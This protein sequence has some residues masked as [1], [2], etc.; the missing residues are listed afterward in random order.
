M[1]DAF[2]NMTA[3]LQDVVHESCSELNLNY[4]VEGLYGTRSDVAEILDR[5]VAYL[6]DAETDGF[7]TI[8]HAQKVRF[9]KILVRDLLERLKSE[10]SAESA[11]I[12][13]GSRETRGP[14]GPLF[15]G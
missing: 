14:V 7:G 15:P 3:N 13:P 1:F 8:S 2:S 4:S 5:A 9:A 6:L 10:L 11:S 12:L